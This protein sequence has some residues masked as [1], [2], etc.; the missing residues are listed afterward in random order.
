[1]PVLEFTAGTVTIIA[2]TLLNQTS[3]A[4]MF[5]PIVGAEIAFHASD[6]LI[7]PVRHEFEHA[8]M[9]LRGE[10]QL[11]GRPLESGAL[12]YL[13]ANRDELHLS[14]GADS[15]ALLLGGAPFT[16]PLVM[17]WNFVGS[18]RDEIAQARKDWMEGE[19]FGDVKAYRGARTPAPELVPLAQAH[20]SD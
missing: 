17:W 1:L 2:G 12:H 3:P 14:G 7:L 5:S 6:R 11:N 13:G 8:L 9:A 18:T 10:L 15:R 20:S 4:Q 19:R 16:D